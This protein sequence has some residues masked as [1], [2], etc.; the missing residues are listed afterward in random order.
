MS[1]ARFSAA[2]VAAAVEEFETYMAPKI[3]EIAGRNGDVK[4]YGENSNERKAK[5]ILI[6]SEEPEDLS[7]LL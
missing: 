3:V 2:E 4:V 1:K 6:D 7:G 5:P